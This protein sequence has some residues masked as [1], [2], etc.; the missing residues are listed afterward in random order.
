MMASESVRQAGG[1]P[2]ETPEI[3]AVES[4]LEP[5]TG[6]GRN[7]HRKPLPPEVLGAKPPGDSLTW[8]VK[9]F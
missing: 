4:T 6:S 3:E 5:A 8:V 7:G 2:G 1:A 9:G